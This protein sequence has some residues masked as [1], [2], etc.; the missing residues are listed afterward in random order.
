MNKKIYI[1]ATGMNGYDTMTT[2]A[3][4]KVQECELLIGAKR[5]LA[6]FSDLEKECFVSYQ[7]DEIREKIQNS[8]YTKIGVLMSGDCGFFSGARKLTFLLEKYDVEIICGIASPIYFCSKLKMKWEDMVFISLHGRN[9][10]IIRNIARNE[11]TFFL[12]GGE[13]KAEH[14]CKTMCDYGMENLKVHIGENL[15]MENER[16]LSDTAQNLQ[17]INTSVLCVMI[18]EN[19][20]HETYLKTNI[21]DSEFIRDKIPMTKS[22][23]RSI[24]VAKLN[25]ESDDIC[26][27]IGCGT[28]SVAVE[29][30]MQCFQGKVCAVDKNELAVSLT[31]QNKY[32]FQCDNIKI[33]LGEVTEIIPAL[34]MPDC[35][36]IGGSSGKL[37]E[38]IRMIFARNPFVKI[39]VTAI[40]LETLSQSIS[41]FDKF[42]INTEITQIAVTRTKKI[43]THTML[44][45]E[46]PIF[47]I[48]N[49]SSTT[50]SCDN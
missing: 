49:L 30:A 36:F 7:Y 4:A 26:W 50:Y 45:A 15:A 43:G 34:P 38:I 27:D 22:E 33:F 18:V 42:G 47:L 6:F 21:P 20:Y 29:M 41:A 39:I 3:L 44:N 17:N 25:I 37:E 12:L 14:I 24:C 32:K 13:I 8:S 35:V 2:Q 16:I 46:N 48:R 9:A 19:P 28:G 23:I 40:S 31:E 11:K 5:M 1:I 10:N